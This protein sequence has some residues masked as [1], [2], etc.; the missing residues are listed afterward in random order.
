MSTHLKSKRFVVQG[1]V[2]G[3]GFRAATQRAAKSLGLR[4]W[5]RNQADGSVLTIAAGEAE[6]MQQFETWLKHGP[7]AARVDSVSSSDVELADL[8]SVFAI[9]P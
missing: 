8:P 4:G 1:Q 9:T 3:V 2:Q 7:P 6:A 5:V